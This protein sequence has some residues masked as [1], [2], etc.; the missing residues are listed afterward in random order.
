MRKKFFDQFS[1]SFESLE[2]S[3]SGLVARM[4]RSWSW[5]WTHQL[6]LLRSRR[7]FDLHLRLSGQEVCRVIMKRKTI[8]CSIP[9]T[10]PYKMKMTNRFTYKHI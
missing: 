5:S 9:P 8:N 6:R 7:C 3:A 1:F 10:D 2:L 4:R